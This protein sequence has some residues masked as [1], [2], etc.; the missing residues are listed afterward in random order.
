MRASPFLLTVLALSA[1]LLA[2][3]G[4][5]YYALRPDP[6][7]LLVNTRDTLIEEPIGSYVKTVNSVMNG[8]DRIRKLGFISVIGGAPNGYP[9]VEGNN[10]KLAAAFQDLLTKALEKRHADTSTGKPVPGLIGTRASEPTFTVIPMEKM[11]SAPSWGK[12][13]SANEDG[14][15]PT[16]RAFTGWS[17]MGLTQGASWMSDLQR[18]TGAQAFIQVGIGPQGGTGKLFLWIPYNLFQQAADRR[19][20]RTTMEV[21]NMNAQVQFTATGKDME[22][23]ADR[24]AATVQA[25]LD[26][27][28]IPQN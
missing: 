3:C 24:L 6:N 4:G 14:A 16:T 21:N 9:G 1:T 26:A 25:Y 28:I 12:K 13:G 15:S 17:F 19:N 27:Y 10:P 8:E 11:Q 23:V 22:Q 18:E 7:D 2:G 5:P 20:L